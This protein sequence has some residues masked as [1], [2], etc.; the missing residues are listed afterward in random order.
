MLQ[1]RRKVRAGVSTSSKHLWLRGENTFVSARRILNGVILHPA[2]T[3]LSSLNHLLR[4][5]LLLADGSSSTGSSVTAEGSVVGFDASS[6]ASIWSSAF[7]SQASSSDA[8]ATAGWLAG[9]VVG[10]A[11]NSSFCCHSV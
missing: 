3:R 11:A 8:S 7:S 4:S 1:W 6:D 10:P 9:P 2:R 5:L